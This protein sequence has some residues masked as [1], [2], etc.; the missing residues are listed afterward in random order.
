MACRKI[1]G[2]EWARPL[3][4]AALPPKRRGG[5]PAQRE[6]L[7]YEAK[8]AKALPH[9]LSGVWFEFEDANGYGRCQ[10]DLLLL[11]PSGVQIV[12][13]KLTYTLAAW[14]QLFFL[15]KPVVEMWLGREVAVA[16]VCKN[17]AG[18][19]GDTGIGE[20][21]DSGALL[22]PW[23]GRAAARP[24]SPQHQAWPQGPLAAALLAHYTSPNAS[25]GRRKTAAPKKG[26]V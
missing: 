8:V 2:L 22:V 23:L 21:L 16:Q 1:V 7:A 6:G 9:G 20:D 24:L 17:L 12:E 15:Y 3:P 13:V 5:T 26:K 18:G 25:K 10:P 14:E 19:A 4:L 11:K